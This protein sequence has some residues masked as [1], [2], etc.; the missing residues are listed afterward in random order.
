MG[1]KG[2]RHSK[3]VGKYEAVRAM[4]GSPMF[5][6]EQI[7]ILTCASCGCKFEQLRWQ[8]EADV[9]VGGGEYEPCCPS[10]S[11]EDQEER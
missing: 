2:T 10:C 6:A 5:G 1:E 11:G 7:V 3:S 9:D 4:G 8:F